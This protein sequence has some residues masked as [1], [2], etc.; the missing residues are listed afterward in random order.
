ML[1]PE[2]HGTGH[3]LR[4]DQRYFSALTRIG[5]W[6]SAE[7]LSGVQLYDLMRDVYLRM[8]AGT[9]YA[10]GWRLSTRAVPSMRTMSPP[11]G[12]ELRW[13]STFGLPWTFRTLTPGTE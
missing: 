6:Y 11:S 13:S 10:G 3:A 12:V 4:L 1:D 2:A 9:R 8:Y 7:K 5:T